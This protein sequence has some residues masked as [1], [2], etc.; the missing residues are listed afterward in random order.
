M[1]S[2]EKKIMQTPSRESPGDRSNQIAC[3]KLNLLISEGII[4]M[5]AFYAPISV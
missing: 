5:L 4:E 2:S 3:Q 1:A